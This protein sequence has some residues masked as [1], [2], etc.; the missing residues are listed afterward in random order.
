MEERREQTPALL[1]DSWLTITG[2]PFP[3]FSIL[4]ILKELKRESELLVFTVFTVNPSS[5][6]FTPNISLKLRISSRIMFFK[7]RCSYCSGSR[8]RSPSR[9]SQHFLY[10]RSAPQWQGSLRPGFPDGLRWCSYERS[11]ANGN[12]AWSPEEHSELR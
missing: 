10:L 7:E 5:A 9:P 11:I 12:L 8:P 4:F 2:H 1:R 3:C 6:G